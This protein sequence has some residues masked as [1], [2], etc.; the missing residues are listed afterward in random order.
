M[1]KE[2][3]ELDG[4]GEAYKCEYCPRLALEK[5][6]IAVHEATCAENPERSESDRRTP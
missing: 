3:V 2:T 6:Q 1:S 4:G 5:R